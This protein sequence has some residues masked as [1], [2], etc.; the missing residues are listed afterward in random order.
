M[1][2]SMVLVWRRVGGRSRWF[3]EGEGWRREVDWG[4][5]EL[6]S[7]AMVMR[8]VFWEGWLR[9]RRRRAARGGLLLRTWWMG[10]S[11]GEGEGDDRLE[12]R[13]R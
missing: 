8:G 11:R 1:R 3:G 7:G 6:E 12:E 2:S 10:V 13:A 9:G 5:L 4:E